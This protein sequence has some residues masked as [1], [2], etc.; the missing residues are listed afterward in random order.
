MGVLPETFWRANGDDMRSETKSEWHQMTSK[1]LRIG[2]LA[3]RMRA[4]GTLVLCVRAALA[5]AMISLF[6]EDATAQTR[7]EGYYYPAVTSTES[8][9]RSLGPRQATREERIA[10]TGAIDTILLGGEKQL[11]F[12]VFAKG[13]AAEKLIIVALDDDIFRSIFRARAQMALLSASLRTTE[14]AK[15]AGLANEITFYDLIYMLNFDSL[16]ISDGVTW[17]HQITFE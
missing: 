12:A 1:R 11:K 7:Q 2:T 13:A 16:T 8:F 5:I 10:F 17:S 9:S 15:N 6:Q 14:F 3:Q 4:G